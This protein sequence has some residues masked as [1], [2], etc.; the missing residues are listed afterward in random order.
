MEDERRPTGNSER[1]FGR[2]FGIIRIENGANVAKPSQNHEFV[3]PRPVTPSFI[4]TEL[5]RHSGMVI[6]NPGLLRSP[7]DSTPT[8]AVSIRRP[9]AFYLAN[10]LPMMQF[11]INLHLHWPRKKERYDSPE[12]D[13]MTAQ[14]LTG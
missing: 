10:K 11:L 7:R 9:C 13:W 4:P 14:I 1:L 8:T 12:P 2:S 5:P 3:V 6:R